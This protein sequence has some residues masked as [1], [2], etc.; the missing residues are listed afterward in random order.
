[1]TRTEIKTAE[2]RFYSHAERFSSFNGCQDA[3]GLYRACAEAHAAASAA[4]ALFDAGHDAK[5]WAGNAEMWANK[6]TFYRARAKDAQL[7]SA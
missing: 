5:R 6:A 7:A 2:Q 3:I 1:M 4:I